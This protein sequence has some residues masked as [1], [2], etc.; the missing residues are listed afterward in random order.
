MK[1]KAIFIRKNN[2]IVYSLKRP[3]VKEQSDRI[4]LISFPHF[5]APD[6]QHNS[7]FPY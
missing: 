7:H 3:E 6:V 2:E 1:G 4:I 5:D